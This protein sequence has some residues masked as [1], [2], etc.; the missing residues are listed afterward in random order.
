MSETRAVTRRGFLGAAFAA[1]LPW[2][3]SLVAAE[4]PRGLALQIGYAAITW[5]DAAETAIDEVAAVGYRGIQLRS[6]VFAKY[7]AKPEELKALL[8][9]KKLELLC[10]SSGNIGDAAAA[11]TEELLE[12]HTKHARFVKALGGRY[13]QITSSRPKGRAPN[14]EE[15]ARAG[16]FLTELGRRTSDLGV[17]VAY[18][19]HMDALS[20]GP[21]ELA[22]LLDAS[23][24][25]YVDLLLDIAHYQQGGGD[26]V[27]G[28]LRHK[29]RLGLL[30]LKDVRKVEPA[31]ASAKNYQFVELGRGR[32][33]VPGVLA[34]LKKIEFRGPA[35]VELDAVP[36]KGQTP[37]ECA[38]INKK[39][40]IDT[41]GLSL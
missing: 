33:D 40:L 39:Y 29:T 8:D 16:R 30:H 21:E 6:N 12:T 14:A 13:L 35:I 10:F 25:R 7:G 23:E 38:E 27:Q 24:G 37:R 9:A 2:P 1:G 3:R 31:N 11:R 41:L 5:G 32:V 20:E 15:F 19:N 17:R 34:S 4:L 36:D 22:Q 26:L 28:V 18:H